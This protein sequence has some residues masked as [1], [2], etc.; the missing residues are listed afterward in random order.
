MPDGLVIV[1]P[2]P[3][4]NVPADPLMMSMPASPPFSVVVPVKLYD[5]VLSAL[6][7]DRPVPLVAFNVPLKVIVPVVC[8]PLT[9]TIAT[10]LVCVMLP[11]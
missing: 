3:K 1:V 10:L 7:N 5:V 4:L 11:P 6:S 8:P 2:V 9:Q